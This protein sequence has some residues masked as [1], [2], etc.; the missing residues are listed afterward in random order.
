MRK[1]IFILACLIPLSIA[2]QCPLFDDKLAALTDRQNSLIVSD[3]GCDEPIKTAT[4]TPLYP[5]P[6]DGYLWS[7]MGGEVYDVRGLKVGILTGG[8]NDVGYLA[9]GVYIVINRPLRQTLRF[10]KL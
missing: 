2:A 9:Q 10:V 7:P 8:D 6:T 3:N 4:L 5:N 1:V